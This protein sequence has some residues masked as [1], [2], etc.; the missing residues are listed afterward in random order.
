MQTH[1]YT[2]ST[3]AANTI[4]LL[5]HNRALFNQMLL[6]E[7][8]KDYKKVKGYWNNLTKL[9]HYRLIYQKHFTNRMFIAS[10]LSQP[11]TVYN[12]YS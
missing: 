8:D 12:P 3:E 6:K 9:L 7:E 11:G 1:Q 5:Y 2:V 4:K 10:I